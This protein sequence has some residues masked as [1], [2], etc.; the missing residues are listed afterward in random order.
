MG[1]TVQNM[2]PHL[3]LE[4]ILGC[5]Q[6]PQFGPLLLFG[7]GGVLTEIYRDTAVALPPLN[8]QLARRIITYPRIYKILQGYRNIPPTN[9]EA[10]TEALVRLSQ[11]VTDFPK[12]SNWILIPCS[13]AK[14][15]GPWPWTAASSSNRPKCPPPGISSLPRT[16]TSTKAPGSSK[17]APRSNS[18]P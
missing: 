14:P 11:L 9:L 8:L 15:A 4:L 7:M 2:I 16:P 1:I 17:T 13:L 12:S 18:G 6:D 10:L 3:D 5:K